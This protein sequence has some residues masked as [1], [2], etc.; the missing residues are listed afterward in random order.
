V[1]EWPSKRWVVLIPPLLAFVALAALWR[2]LDLGSLR[3]LDQVVDAIH[4]LRARPWAPMY[5]IA[6]YGVLTVLF[7][8]ITVLIVATALA[9]GPVAGS[10]Y[11]FCGICVASSTTYWAGRLIGGEA[12]AQL[13][14][15]RVARFA[16]ALHAHA[17]R[18]S[19]VARLS[20][21]GNFAAMNMLAGSIRI[22]F[23]AFISGTIIGATPGLLVFSFFSER[24]AQAMRTPSSDDHLFLL[25]GLAILAAVVFL[26][27]RMLARRI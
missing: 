14:G 27:R 3:S 25:L 18:A 23:P 9:F 15:P 17:F 6:G 7:V 24:A 12:F 1:Q 5:V 16:A 20:P 8:P 26:L 10:W 11:A 21:V 13:V 4:G 22:P 19:L 2:L